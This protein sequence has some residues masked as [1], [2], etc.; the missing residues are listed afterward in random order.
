[1]KEFEVV[2]KVT[3]GTVTTIECDYP[4]KYYPTA[5]RWLRITRPITNVTIY[6]EKELA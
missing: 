4:Y 5:R 2:C 6:K 1:M 3:N